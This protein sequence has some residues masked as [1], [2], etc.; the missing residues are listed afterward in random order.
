MKETVVNIMESASP[1][2]CSCALF[3]LKCESDNCGHRFSSDA[4][5]PLSDLEQILEG[6][7][8]LML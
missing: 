2:G 4:S 3:D 5:S 7:M 1:E 8:N 6:Q